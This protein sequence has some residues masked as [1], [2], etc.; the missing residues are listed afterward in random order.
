[1]PVGSADGKLRLRMLVDRTTLE[2]FAD[3]GRTSASFYVPPDR[4]SNPLGLAVEGGEA[5]VDTLRV[6][7]MRSIWPR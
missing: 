6:W 4:S 5:A 2:I 3:G 7:E 1:M